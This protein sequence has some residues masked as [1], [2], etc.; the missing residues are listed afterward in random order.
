M[1]RMFSV[2]QSDI[3]NHFEREKHEISFQNFM[4]ILFS[5]GLCVSKSRLTGLQDKGV[6]LD[7]SKYFLKGKNSKSALF[8]CRNYCE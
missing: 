7:N 8:M 3:F 6:K 4:D 5:D 1:H 2:V